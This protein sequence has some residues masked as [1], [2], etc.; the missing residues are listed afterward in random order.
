MGN[1]SRASCRSFLR[2][3]MSNA[4]IESDSSVAVKLINEGAP[5]DHTQGPL[6]EDAKMLAIRTHTMIGTSYISSS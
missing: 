3:E 1:L 4:K 5:M 2:K 6:V